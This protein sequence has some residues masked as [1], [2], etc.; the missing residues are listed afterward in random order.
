MLRGGRDI[1]FM[2]FEGGINCFS[3]I[4]FMLPRINVSFCRVVRPV[5]EDVLLC[6]SLSAVIVGDNHSSRI[7]STG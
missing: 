2:L 3:S 5:S 4:D 7:S 6:L 1:D